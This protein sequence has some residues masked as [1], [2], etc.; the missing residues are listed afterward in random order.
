MYCTTTIR[1]KKQ[2][3]LPSAYFIERG[4]LRN[5]TLVILA[6][7]TALRISNLLRLQWEDLYDFENNHVRNCAE[8]QKK[9]LEN[10]RQSLLTKLLSPLLHFI[11]PKSINYK[12]FVIENPHTKKDISYIQ[13]YRITCSVSKALAFHSRTSC[14]SS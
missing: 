8:I 5:H 12:Q 6:I 2:F 13:S 14:H 4:Q 3:R 7:H 9:R 1:N 10:S 11:N